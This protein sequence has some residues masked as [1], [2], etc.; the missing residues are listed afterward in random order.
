ML[1]LTVINMIIIFVWIPFLRNALLKICG[2]K[3]SWQARIGLSLVLTRKVTLLGQSRISNFNL[4][5]CDGVTLSNKSTIGFMNI[6]K[7]NFKI[8]LGDN[9]HIGNL[10]IIKNNG[11]L[12]IPRASVLRLGRFS[13]IT[14]SHYIDMSC[15]VLFGENSVLG[16]RSSSLWTHGFVHFNKGVDR[17]MKLEPINI[18]NGV[19][20][21]SNCV[22]NPDTKIGDDINIGAGVSVAG[23]IKSPGLYVN[24]KLRF[25]NIGSLEDFKKGRSIDYDYKT[26]NP[27][28]Y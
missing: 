1:R 24:Q 12:I 25:I 15:D 16:G 3:I 4:I 23:T 6:I 17:L 5:K 22:V 14:A 13:K 26:G 8:Y 2:F 28:F 9:S 27:R 18:G 11:L 21:G 19:Y 7:G 20:V 10:N